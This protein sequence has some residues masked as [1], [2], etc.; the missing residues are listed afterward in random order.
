MLIL[1]RNTHQTIVIGDSITI[2]IL[3]IRGNQVKVGIDAPRE[4]PVHR[5]EIYE[6]IQAEGDR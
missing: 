6:K 3:N 1:S 2:K 5:Q 4:V